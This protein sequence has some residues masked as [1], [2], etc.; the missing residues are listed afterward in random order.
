MYRRSWISTVTRLA[1]SLLLGLQV[2]NAATAN[3]QLQPSSV[4]YP[5]DDAAMQNL[6]STFDPTSNGWQKGLA[7][8]A[9]I[10]S[11]ER[12]HDAKYLTALSSSFQYSV[13]WRTKFYDDIGWY[14]N[15]WIR[16]YDV[17][18]DP[19]YLNEAMAI[20]STMTAG[21]DGT[22]GGGLW[23]STDR[24]YKNAITNELFLL[25]AA[26]LHRRLASDGTGAG[27]YY[28]WAFRE[29][30]WFQNSGMINGQHFVNDGLTSGCQNNNGNPYTYNQ[31]VILGG[32]VEL[33]RIDGDRGHLFSAEQIA[34]ATTTGQVYSNGVLKEA[35]EP[36][37]GSG[38]GD[39]FKG[40][41]VQGLAR[42]YNADRGN[43]PQYGTFIDNNAN[44][45][46]NTDRTGSNGI[47]LLWVGSP[48][49]PNLGTQTSGALLLGE[50][51]LLDAGGETSTPPVLGSVNLNFNAGTASPNVAMGSSPSFASFN[52]KLYAAFR[53]NDSRN[54]LFIASSTDGVNFGPATG[55]SNI[56]IGSAP[57]LTVFN[58]KLYV[59]FQANDASHKLFV[60]SSTDGVTFPA[61]TGYS[62]IQIG[63]APSLAALNGV[64]YVAFQANDSGNAI[65][66]GQSPDG[67]N[68]TTGITSE[69][70]NAAPSLA[71]FNNKLYLG[72]RSNDSRN[73]LFVASSS[74]GSFSGSTAYSNIAMGSSPALAAANGAL[75]VTFQANDSSHL[76]FVTAS[77]TGTGFPGA[78][79]FGSMSTGSAPTAAA[80]GS[81]LSIGFMAN[82]SRHIL[83]T[84][85]N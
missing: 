54:I 1:L 35:C 17:T 9:I 76:L 4:T 64:L 23:W 5:R 10:N 21:W 25:A 52:G 69:S 77:T 57:S 62:N 85:I 15:A 75:Y 51:A 43:K 49:T 63:G 22:C 68:F 61:A 46:W 14:A 78:T 67:V 65:W 16:A 55:Y 40:V 56:Q 8:D 80:F 82:D 6:L 72:F 58:N 24:A 42:L 81:T 33:W 48:G 66:M 27:S 50:E 60:T 73:I 31:G 59:A 20:F 2:V 37:C 32:L 70:T 13:G 45:V 34:E 11:Y 30:S 79:S 39:V 12:T 18:G 84:T 29:W 74:N 19:K 71:A 83:F 3:A 28:D 7:L 47:G 44:S 41:F 53:S 38:D 26:R 36:N